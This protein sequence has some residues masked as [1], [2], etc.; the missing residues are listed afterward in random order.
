MLSI[1]LVGVPGV[2]DL[3]SPCPN[4]GEHLVSLLTPHSALGVAGLL[5]FYDTCVDLK[6]V[7]D[8][9]CLGGLV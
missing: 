5:L 7:L 3:S 2:L 4:L 1:S 6:Q 9:C 8:W